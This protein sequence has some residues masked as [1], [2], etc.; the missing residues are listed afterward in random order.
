MRKTLTLLCLMLGWIVISVSSSQAHTRSMSFSKWTFDKTGASVE[1][2]I[3]LLELTRFDGGAPPDSYFPE[4]LILLDAGRPCAYSDV[5]RLPHAPEGWA[6]YHW[7][8]HRF[9]DSI[10]SPDLAIRSTLMEETVSTHAHFAR[11]EPAPGSRR[12][13]LERIL[14]AQS[15]DWKL[16]AGAPGSTGGSTIADY[17]QMGLLHILEG[18]DHLAFILALILM[19]GSIRELGIVI[20]GFTIAH[21]ITLGLAT[22]GV[23]KPDIRAVEIHIGFSIALV[24]A[25]NLWIAAG[26]DR[27]MPW[28]WTGAL[29][30]A[31]AVSAVTRSVLIPLAWAG[32]AAF[33]F[34]HFRLLEYSEHPARLRALISFA[35]GLVHG[36]GFAGVLMDM[37]LSTSRLVPALFG[38]NL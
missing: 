14:D 4:H 28:L 17:I 32:L 31:V 6:V 23:L 11:I 16:G 1:L 24:A 18:R 25:E 10:G 3:P 5:V 13:A 9:N 7:R 27:L 21:S 19:A 8:I 20:T 35:F 30:L 15:T 38:F 34:G 29:L 26:K 37:E 33:S 12:A 2:R 36:F 22:L